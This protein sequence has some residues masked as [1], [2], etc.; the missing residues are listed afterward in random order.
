M[1]RIK[2][3]ALLKEAFHHHTEIGDLVE[4]LYKALGTGD[5]ELV[6][7]LLIHLE[8]IELQHYALEDRLMRAVDYD[9]AAAHRA[10]HAALLD[11][12]AL[13]NRTLALENPAA[14][15]PHVV[16]HLDSAIAHMMNAD[17]EL[18]RFVSARAV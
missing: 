17:D 18:G 4:R 12:L 10:E 15:N 3:E 7:S 9:R 2:P 6:K 13:I 8:A 1:T 16:A 5:H 11:T 14:V